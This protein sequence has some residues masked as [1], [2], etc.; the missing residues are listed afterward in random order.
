MELTHKRA[1]IALASK[2]PSLVGRLRLCDLKTDIFLAANVMDAVITYLALQ[3]GS[4]VTEFNSILSGIMD[5]IGIGPT[6]ILKVILC[7]G[8]LWV[9]RKTKKEKIL[10]PLSAIFAAVA[11]SNLMVARANGIAL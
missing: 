6:L 3:H 2:K 4:N 8:I 5:T 10:V 1:K 11:I 9:L 7:I